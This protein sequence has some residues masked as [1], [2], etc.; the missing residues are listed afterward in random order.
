MR[1]SMKLTLD[2][3]VRSLRSGAHGLADVVESG[4]RPRP[5]TDRR[6]AIRPD[7]QDQAAS[8]GRSGD[9]RSGR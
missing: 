5:A 1:L 9:D 2:D 7:R 4:Y 3:L 8:V 6:Q